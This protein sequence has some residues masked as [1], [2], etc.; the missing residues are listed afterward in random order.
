MT[1]PISST[2]PVITPPAGGATSATI[3]TQPPPPATTVNPP[4][5]KRI[6]FNK[7]LNYIVLQAV[8]FTGTHV[9]PYGEAGKRFDLAAATFWNYMGART[10]ADT[11]K[12]S[13]KTNRD[14]LNSSIEQRRR[15]V[16]KTSVASG[17]VEEIE[18]SEVLADDLIL[19]MDEWVEKRKE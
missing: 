15:L 14:R 5:K 19:E 11:H 7:S 12:P 17:I 18:G 6:R 8:S 16:K 9:S 10:T 3:S 4:K 13:A 2:A 1:S